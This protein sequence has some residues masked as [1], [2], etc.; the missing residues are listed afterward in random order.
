MPVDREQQRHRVLCYGIRRVGRDA[1]HTEL[2]K[3]G[4]D[5]HVVE[6]R[7]A[8]GN[9]PDAK[10]IQRVDDRFIQRIVDEHAHAVKP[11]GQR[12]CVRIELRLKVLDLQ[13]CPGGI[14]VKARLIIRLGVKKRDFHISTS[15]DYICSSFCA[16]MKIYTGE[17]LTGE[18]AG[19]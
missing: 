12:D 18:R 15:P 4:P 9:S 16:D 13:P 1:E 3:A 14:G 17:A 19:A 11:T 10:R 7:A 5:I 2:S 6:A 8:K